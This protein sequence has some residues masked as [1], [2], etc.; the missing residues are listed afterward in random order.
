[1]TRCM[2]EA[3]KLFIMVDSAK[4]FLLAQ[5]VRMDVEGQQRPADQRRIFRLVYADAF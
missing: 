4:V 2:E 5:G 1:M 3:K